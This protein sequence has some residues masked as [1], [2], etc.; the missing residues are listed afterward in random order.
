MKVIYLTTL[1]SLLFVINSFAQQE[2]VFSEWFSNPDNDI[3]ECTAWH[4]F[5]DQLSP[6]KSYKS[7]LFKGSENETGLF[8]DDP[9][10]ATEL[11]AA[12]YTKKDTAFTVNGQF[13]R[14]HVYQGSSWVSASSLGNSFPAEE[15]I[16]GPE[17]FAVRACLENGNF[18]GISGL[19]CNPP[20]QR[21]D[22]IFTYT[23]V[24]L[25]DNVPATCPEF[26]DGSLTVKMGGG[27]APYTFEWSNGETTTSGNAVSGYTLLGHFEESSYYRSDAQAATMDAAQADAETNFGHIVSINNAEENAWLIAN[28]AQ[29]GDNLGGTDRDEEGIWIWASGEPFSY[30]NWRLG[31]PNNGG[32]TGQS[33]IQ[34]Y[35]DGTWDDV[36]WAH[37]PGVRHI[38]EL[39]GT[40]K[41]ENLQPGEYTVTV[42]DADGEVTTSTF[43]VDPETLEISFAMTQSSTCD[44]LGDGALEAQVSGG[45][46][47]YS[48]VWSSGET[49]AAISDKG[50]GE[51]T[52]TITDANN[53]ASVEAAGT[54]TSNDNTKPTIL[55]KAATI[56]L[57]ENGEAQVSIAEVN[58]GSY[59]D[60]SLELS[61]GQ[62]D[63]DCSHLIAGPA[64]FDGVTALEFDGTDDYLTFNSV[65]PQSPSHTMALWIKT[66]TINKS[67]F[68]WGGAGVNNYSGMAFQGGKIRYY[69][70]NGIAPIP[71]ITGNTSVADG[72]WHHVA[73]SRSN[74]GEVK[75]FIDGNLDGSGTVSNYVNGV[76]N[77]SLGAIFANGVYQTNFEGAI[78]EFAFWPTVLTQEAIADLI[79][80][81]PVNPDV[82]L[83][84]EDGTG[85]SI[86]TDLSGNGNNGNLNNMDSNTSWNGFGGPVITPNCAAQ[87]TTMLIGIDISGNMDS[88][89]AVLTV[90]DTIAPIAIAQSQT[91]YLN[92]DGEAELYPADLDNG[93]T[94]NC[95]VESFTA[96]KTLF[97]CSDLGMNNV[98]LSA[99]DMSGNSGSA[100]T[101]VE[102]IDLMK[103][104]LEVQ[105]I[106][107]SLDADGIA[108]ITTDLVE[109][110]SADNCGIV[111]KS[112][113]L[114]T[115]S[116]ADLNEAV[117]VE[118]TVTDASGNAQTETF[119]VT[120]RDEI[121]PIANPQ[122]YTI[123]LDENGTAEFDQ[124]LIAEFIGGNDTDDCSGIDT[125]SHSLNQ[126][127][128]TCED[129]GEN[130]IIY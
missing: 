40:S 54:I 117:L 41:I 43:T 49:T 65:I 68:G 15:C 30:T 80:S 58:D 62:T 55:A 130:E 38:M 13:W 126:M 125:E 77:S 72:N 22:L 102:V 31:E 95:S 105:N 2:V 81:G 116:C 34:I 79:C 42:T 37:A 26:S 70:G 107:V 84:F 67:V 46:A 3:S 27:K 50:V 14:V 92:G 64:S 76:T 109:V 75:I 86:A 129:L 113:S 32:G 112:L 71:S 35:A 21:I 93:S 9:V 97:D 98:I 16:N 18:G 11:A 24:D 8:L 96:S 5:S 123:A 52:V 119:E 101:Q 17:F 100:A 111:S 78:D 94:D 33:N 23:G 87:I 25:V 82:Y 110:S 39:P 74:T 99:A 121:A 47:P 51:Y 29:A 66:S 89:L 1:F 7:V 91:I 6:D 48:F 63:Y 114:S 88:A 59:D 104:V 103:P 12:V 124:A 73:I 57:D 20:S 120:V 44:E 90:L 106:E 85:S 56:Y 118:M 128:F 28:G 4:D 60:C 127:V 19:T 45:T 83:K 10:G 61:L 36:L 108:T 69:A 122:A 53:C 115:F